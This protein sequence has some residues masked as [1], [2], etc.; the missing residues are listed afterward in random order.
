M[1]FFKTQAGVTLLEVLVGFVIFSASLVA[2]LDYVSQHIYL[3]QL[4]SSSLKNIQLVYDVSILTETG[5]KNM[6][7][8]SHSFDPQH[9]TAVVTPISSITSRRN[10]IVLNQYDYQV[11]NPNGTLEW[12][13][14]KV[15]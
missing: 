14:L 3:Q 1:R 2:V 7:G 13:V 4:T 11:N 12:S 10:Q 9:V 8:Y 5:L 6:D 15:E